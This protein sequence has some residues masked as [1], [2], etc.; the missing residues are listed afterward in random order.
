[1]PLRGEPLLPPLEKPRPHRRANLV[2]AICGKPRSNGS[3]SKTC[4]PACGYRMR[5][6]KLRNPRHC[7][8]CGAEFWPTRQYKTGWERHC[9]KRCAFQALRSKRIESKCL[10]C[11]TSVLRAVASTKRVRHH[12]CSQD[13]MKVYLRGP[14]SPL[15]R[16]DSDPNRGGDWRRLAESI[17]A[18]DGFR[19]RRCNRTQ[20]EN[21]QKLSVDHII[22]WRAFD[23]KTEAND[24]SN[25][26]SLCRS[27][28]SIKTHLF[29]RLWL[30]GDRIGMEQY[31]RAINL[32][33]VF[34]V[35]PLPSHVRIITAS[36]RMRVG[37]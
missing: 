14:N 18:R 22:P 35:K 17:R 34:G 5:K 27:C 2:C 8:A 3:A 23:D 1:M 11:G 28:H 10:Q 36:R 30:K 16:G 29:E 19:C 25:L 33:P 15:Y 26:A 31:K 20:D 21:G 24:P 7:A 13:C 32:P 37:D 12:F 9:S 4:S 6:L